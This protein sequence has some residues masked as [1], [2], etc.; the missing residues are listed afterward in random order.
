VDD[1]ANEK[2]G[3]LLIIS[4][5]SGV[6]KTTITHDV[7]RQLNGKFSVSMT[8]RPKTDS[9]TEGVDYHF[10]DRAEFDRHR[11]AGDLLEWAE[12]FGNCYGTPRKPVEQALAAGE[13]MLLEIDVDGAEQVK[14]KLPDA[15]AIFVLPPSEDVLLQRLR[16]RKR[17][18]ESVIQRRF[19]K[20]R[21]E[22]ARAKASGVYDHFLV[23]DNLQHA[24]AEAVQV[25]RTAMTRRTN[26]SK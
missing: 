9:D 18:D 19:A 13:L 23:N 7:E 26:A 4:G 1:P 5:P 12:V 24:I 22:I 21:D 20:A 3:M 8:T 25:V 11:D 2:Q 14:R 15:F 6:G 10:I 17:E 16:S